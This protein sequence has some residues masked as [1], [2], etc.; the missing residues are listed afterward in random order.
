MS[1]SSHCTAESGGN[2]AVCLQE[3]VCAAVQ[4]DA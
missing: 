1:I 2:A 4:T 3:E